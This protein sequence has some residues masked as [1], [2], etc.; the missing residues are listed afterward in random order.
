MRINILCEESNLLQVREKMKNENIL[1]IKCSPTGELPVTHYF[2]TMVVNQEKADHLMAM[3]ELTTIELSGPK[4]FL[5]K[6]DLK[7]IK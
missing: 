2:C 3:Q 4:E 7:I 5:E 6:W 1:K